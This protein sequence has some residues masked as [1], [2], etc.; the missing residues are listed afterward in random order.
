MLAFSALLVI[1]IV[2]FIRAPFRQYILEM[3]TN[4]LI[5]GLPVFLILIMFS[6]FMNSATDP[7]I[8]TL[9]FLMTLS[10]LLVIYK[11][12]AATDK[13]RRSK[14]VEDMLA[15]QMESQHR[16]YEE[17]RQ[18]FEMGR[19]YR[20]D[21]RHHLAALDVLVQQSDAKEAAEYIC[22]L[23]EQLDQIKVE[24]YCEDVTVNAILSFYIEKARAADCGVDVEIKISER[25]SFE[26]LDLC[27][28]LSN[29]L[30][31][32]IHACRKLEKS[33]R[34]ISFYIY[35]EDKGKMIISV[36]N[37][38]AECI[39]FDAD[40][41]PAEPEDK[42]HGVGLR[43][44]QA[45]VRKY[46]GLLSCS[47]KEGVFYTRVVLFAPQSDCQP[48]R[49]AS[50]VKKA[51]QNM[52]LIF[53]AA[54]LAVN[55][56]PQVVTA[57]EKVPILGPVVRIVSLEQF[58]FRWGASAIKMD[59]P[60]VQM[61]M[62]DPKPALGCGRSCVEDK[63]RRGTV[64]ALESQKK[65][66]ASLPQIPV[67]DPALSDAVDDF[68]NDLTDY[69][70][71]LQAMFA[72][73]VIRKYDGYVALDT[74]YVILCDNSEMLS[75]RFNTTINIGGSSQYTKYFT[76]NKRIKKVIK[77]GDLFKED[78]PYRSV[79]SKEILSQMSR[80]TADGDAI[81][82][83]PGE[84]WPE[85]SCFK[86]IDDGQNFYINEKGKLV[87]AFDEYQVA[88]GSMGC[89]EFVIPTEVIKKLLRNPS[90]VK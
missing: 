17:I 7:L 45:V 34:R 47:Q 90:L 71:H 81:Y 54:A 35:F 85:E 83:I 3:N 13:A 48:N 42:E 52:L 29:A 8:F 32:A 53:A 31:N 72:W 41:L 43:S 82:F 84:G 19:A 20:H 69:I 76:L 44:M 33:D 57:A 64:L 66:T 9:L 75:I 78:V 18:K 73:N 89:P 38:S 55:M 22:R 87:V 12:L 68:N 88:P 67:N 70:E 10:M 40:G 65:G 5:P 80:Q 15:L 59:A 51:V 63:K 23:R 16:Q 77:I 27:V 2:K 61:T 56:S 37:S 28:I 14:A 36:S 50:T 74:R 26:A 49:G 1:F 39:T 25:L 30:E 24:E 21:M 6:Y 86:E 60:F 62:Y 11:M 46:N 79:I 4:W 58:R